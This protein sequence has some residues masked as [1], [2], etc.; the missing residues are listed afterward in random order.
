MPATDAIVALGSNQD[1]R[2]RMLRAARDLVARL[3]GTLAIETSPVY[4]TEPVGVAERHRE[5]TYLNAVL[6]V[7]TTLDVE[8]WSRQLHAIEDALGRVRTGEPNAPRPIDVDLITFGDIRLSR[9][10]LTLPHPRASQRRFVLQPL[11]DLR[12][13]L[14]LPGE[15]VS[16]SALLA[17]LP[18]SPWVRSYSAF[19]TS[20]PHSPLPFLPLSTDLPALLASGAPVIRIPP[21]TY[22]LDAPLRIPSCTT[23]LAAPGT[24]F[25]ANEGDRGEHPPV[26]C[27]QSGAS[28]TAH[29]I[30]IH[31][32]IWQGNIVFHG[33][34][35]L[36]LSRLTIH[37]S[38]H[39]HRID[40]FNLR[41]LS[42]ESPAP[43]ALTLHGPVRHGSLSDISG[44]AHRSLIALLADPEPE[45][46]K[47]RNSEI[48]DAKLEAEN[49][50]PETGNRKPW[51]AAAAAGPITHLA[52]RRLRPIGCAA[53]FEH[54]VKSTI[55]PRF[56]KAP[57]RSRLFLDPGPV[58][59]TSPF[60]PRVHPVTGETASFHTGVDLV[61]CI[62]KRMLETG[63]C[64]WAD[65]TVLAAADTDGPAGTCV[66]LD[67]GRGLITRYF[68]MEYGSL[69]V[70]A[71]QRI[72]KGA[73]LGWMGKTGRSTGE[74]LHFQMELDGTP[75]DPVV[76]MRG[77][78]PAK[79]RH[80]P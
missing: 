18:S 15:S 44:T 25:I 5:R 74:H 60:G 67:H 77:V 2:M 11:A 3:P 40:G 76:G 64:A 80:V 1:D 42:I 24:R 28:P 10:D 75:I 50:K 4:E 29:D 37:G 27:E 43:D 8:T 49:W 61:L 78:R 30:A 51:P 20:A 16:V 48:S 56:P 21:G 58:K 33:I 6:A 14:V 47:T 38:L 23:L 39:L 57:G 55:A 79:T 65:G 19:P 70:H 34:R 31:G 62:G 35:G 36:H 66:V 7:R 52:F 53:F 22:R 72:R 12:P 63:I 26:L 54:R 46:P 41:C 71:G 13:D 59:V 69:R 17:A 32:G 45:N 9:P 73:L 68:H